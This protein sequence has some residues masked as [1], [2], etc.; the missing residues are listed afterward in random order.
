MGAAPICVEAAGIETS[1]FGCTSYDR[2]GFDQAGFDQAGFD[3][4]SLAKTSFDKTDINRRQV[5]RFYCC[6]AGGNRWYCRLRARCQQQAV[7]WFAKSALARALSV[8]G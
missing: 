6:R 1:V 7:F 2:T 3:K 4:T 5:E 8:G